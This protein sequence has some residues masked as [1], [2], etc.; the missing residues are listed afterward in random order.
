MV[1]ACGGLLALNHWLVFQHVAP[2]ASCMH[3]RSSAGVVHASGR[4]PEAEGHSS[5]K[6]PAFLAVAP[7]CKQALPLATFSHGHN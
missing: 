5:Q 6:Q 1:P 3:V 7:T 4:Q 2:V